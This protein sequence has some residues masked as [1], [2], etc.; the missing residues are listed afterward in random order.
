MQDK[1]RFKGREMKKVTI[2]G[3][4]GVNGVCEGGQ[5]IKTATVANE[6]I[7]LYGEQQVKC[8]KTY[9]RITDL[10][11]VPLY[12]IKALSGS[13]NVIILPAQNGLRIIAPLLAIANKLY[14]RR[15]HYAVIGGWL[16]K[17]LENRKYL[18]KQLKTFNGIYPETTTVKNALEK[19]G[20]N[21]VYVM[22]NF[23]DLKVLEES[24]LVHHTAQPYKLCLFSRVMKEKGVQEAVNAVTKIN[25]S[26]GKT[27]YSLDIYGPVW[28]SQA[29]W[30]ENLQK[31]F[32]D[33]VKYGGVVP[34]DKSIDVLK[35]YFAL[36]FPTRFYTE[37]IPGT[38]IDAY[39]AG[40]P[41]IASRWESFDDLI[42]NGVT[43]YGYT[44]DNIEEF[45]NLLKDI[46]NNPDKIEQLKSNCIK[47]AQGY[48]PE[49]ALSV[50]TQRL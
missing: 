41:V 32:P 30:F 46:A 22:P 35:D 18:T 47:K 7:K 8:L 14:K 3:N 31:S 10:I 50:L 37:G 11:M 25:R 17:M 5:N 9:G 33:Y 23:K 15:I 44:F 24:Q 21:N 13:S 26:A 42:D 38:I 39:A 6:L 29:E 28:P 49:N 19:Q 36:L 45:E 40:V 4:F 27:V 34:F 20:F 48:I 1:S 16:P 43:G 12:V 2:I